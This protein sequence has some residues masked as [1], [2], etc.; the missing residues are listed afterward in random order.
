M[1]KASKI[2][3]AS[4]P[5]VVAIIFYAG[6]L[7]WRGVGEAGVAWVELIQIANQ[8]A[9]G[10]EPWKLATPHPALDLLGIPLLAIGEANRLQVL[11][12]TSAVF[13]GLTLP[14]VWMLGHRLGRDWGAISACVLFLGL[15]VVSGAAT[16]TSPAAIMLCLWAWF[17]ALASKPDL[18]WPGWLGL[19]LLAAVLAAS[20]VPFLIWLAAWFMLQII[21]SAREDQRGGRESDSPGFIRASTIPL[22]AFI[23][24]LAA[25]AAPLLMVA[26]SD[27]DLATGMDTWLRQGLLPQ[28]EAVVFAGETFV[29][30]RPPVFSGFAWWLIQTPAVFVVLALI[31]IVG[32]TERGRTW[33]D[34]HIPSHVEQGFALGL[35]PMTLVFLGLMPWLTRSRAFGGA[36]PVLLAQ[37]IM[38]ALAGAAI[39]WIV[40]GLVERLKDSLSGKA[41]AAIAGVLGALAFLPGI[42]ETARLHPLQ[43]AKYNIFVGGTDGAV[44]SGFPV[45]TDDTLPTRVATKL[46]EL[47]DVQPVDPGS[48]RRQLRGFISDGIIPPIAFA[49]ENQRPKVRLRAGRGAAPDET[50]PFKRV[51]WKVDEITV[52]EVLLLDPP[53]AEE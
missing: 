34:E 19:G 18:R 5:A 16:T 46:A 8:A 11:G 25:V 22:G 30:S 50:Q 26:L 14:A 35:V 32:G 17:F 6:I 41:I 39:T 52:Y 15:P 10:D 12:W 44:D 28:A 9:L 38:A 7:G 47:A 53:P 23:P 21:T 3:G 51:T 27:G 29:S 20:W 13:A 43:A 42:Y 4:L 36:D 1:N 48:Y 40:A 2:A 33:L 49:E 37:P 24:L 31:G 45:V